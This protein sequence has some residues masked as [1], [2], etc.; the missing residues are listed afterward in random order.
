MQE[1]EIEVH[2]LLR[3]YLRVYLEVV[4]YSDRYM[5]HTMV[6]LTDVVVG[7]T[8][9]PPHHRDKVDLGLQLVT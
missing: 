2:E 9:H 6:S 8:F 3:P 1:L 4:E 5:C 7:N